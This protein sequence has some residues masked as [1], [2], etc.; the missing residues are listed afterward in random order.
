MF[1]L[2]T[3]VKDEHIDFQGIVDG[4]YYPFYMEDCRH[5][6]LKDITGI[7]IEEYAERGLNL[8]LAQ[9]TLKFKKSLK[10]GDKLVVN[11]E[12]IPTENSRSKFSMKQQ[13][14]CDGKV[15]AE[16]TFIATCVPSGGGRPFIPDE[17]KAQLP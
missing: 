13:I 10:K 3:E 1:E 5:Q 14:L 11:C 9:Y 7:S 2:K 16:A 17:I 4:L 12:L 6:F 15:A 8:V